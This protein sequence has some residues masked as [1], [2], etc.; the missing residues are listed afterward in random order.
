M[1]GFCDLNLECQFYFGYVSIYEQFKFHA[2]FWL[3]VGK[4]GAISVYDEHDE[5]FYISVAG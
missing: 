3:A 2:Q 1:T 4:V 5:D